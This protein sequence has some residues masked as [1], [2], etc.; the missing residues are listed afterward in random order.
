MN[1]RD[2]A[3]TRLAGKVG[4]LTH[5]E[6]DESVAIRLRYIG[7]GTVTSVTVTTGTNIVMVTSDGGTDTYAFATYTTMG[8]L[9]DAINA[10]GIFEA[11]LLDVLRSDASASKLVDGAISSSVLDGITIWDALIDTSALDKA[12]VCVTADRGFSMGDALKGKKWLHLKLFKYYQDINGA[13]AGAVKIT[14]RVGSTET[15]VASYASVDTTVTSVFD[16]TAS[17]AYLSVK[18]GEELILSVQDAT[19]ITDSASNFIEAFYFVV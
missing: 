17:E 2:I 15:T 6:D 9:V 1:S 11:K 12:S 18:P 4:V 8:T 14:K 10:D 3:Q 7:T 19:S 5:L 16:Y 13:T